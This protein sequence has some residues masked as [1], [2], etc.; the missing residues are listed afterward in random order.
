MPR[1]YRNVELI[2]FVA[3]LNHKFWTPNEE[4]YPFMLIK[5][6]YIYEPNIIP[7][8]SIGERKKKWIFELTQSRSQ[9]DKKKRINPFFDMKIL[10]TN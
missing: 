10:N 2:I 3:N 9:F 6:M 4:Y 5:Q 1:I 8:T 7:S